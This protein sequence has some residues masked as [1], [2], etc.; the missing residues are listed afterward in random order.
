MLSAEGEL[1]WVVPDDM[2]DGDVEAFTV[3]ATDSRGAASTTVGYVFIAIPDDTTVESGP[4]F[5]ALLF[6]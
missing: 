1:L 5:C 2:A 6:R 4:P 3:T